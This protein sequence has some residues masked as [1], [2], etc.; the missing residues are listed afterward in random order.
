MSEAP[1]HPDFLDED[2]NPL[3]RA[4]LPETFKAIGSNFRQL[5]REGRA[6]IYER[7]EIDSKIPSFEVV[8][9]QGHDGRIIKGAIVLPSEFYPSTSSWGSLGWSYTRHPKDEARAWAKFEELKARFA[10]KVI[11]PARRRTPLPAPVAIS[12]SDAATKESD[13]SQAASR[14]I[15]ERQDSPPISHEEAIRRALLKT[16]LTRL[17]RSFPSAEPDSLGDRIG[18]CLI[19]LAFYATNTDET[20]ARAEALIVEA[21]N[22]IAKS[23]NPNSVSPQSIAKDSGYARSELPASTVEFTTP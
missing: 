4:I 15:P 22:Q 18:C 5:A 10:P 20:R 8:I 21:R 13:A 7:I 1:I 16:E 14:A 17:A 12:A 19:A 6:A 23:A 3:P 11:V 9:I 2:G